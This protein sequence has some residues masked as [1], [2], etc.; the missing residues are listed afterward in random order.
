LEK[1]LKSSDIEKKL[2]IND[3]KLIGELCF[4]QAIPMNT[5][6]TTRSSMYM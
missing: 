5:S 6:S 3:L 2:I 4:Q 1:E